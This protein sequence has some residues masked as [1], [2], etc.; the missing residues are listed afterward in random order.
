MKNIVRKSLHLALVLLLAGCAGGNDYQCALPE[1]PA[2]VVSFDLPKLAVRA[3]LDASSGDKVLNRFK[4]MAKS[5]LEGSGDMVDRIFADVAESGLDLNDKVYFFTNEEMATVGLLAKV[6]DSSKLESVMEVLHKQQLCQAVRETDGCRWTVLGKWLLAYSDQALLVLGDNKW[7]D[8]SKLVRQASMWLRQK[9]DQGFASKPDFKKIQENQSE[10]V[11]YTS[12]QL[13]SRQALAPLT[14]G[15]S[16]EVDLNKIKALT[17]V[18][19]E[20]GKVTLDVDPLVTDD[21]I[22]GLIEKKSQ[23]M[24]PV[25]GTYLDVFPSKTAFWT[26][27]NLKGGEFYQFLR[28][29]PA[30][31]KFFDYSDLPITLDFGRIFEAID[32]DVSVAITDPERGHFILYADV[33]Q[34]EFLKVFTELRPMIAKT[35]GMLILEDRGEN[36][37]C[38]ATH[39]GSL[40]NM[41][42]GP[43]IFWLGVKNGRFYFT[44]REDLIDSRVLGLSLRDC[45]WG[46]RV[47]GQHFFAVSNW[48]GLRTFEFLIHQ[49]VLSSVPK[50]IPPT[51]DYITIESADSKH[52]HI[53]WI[54]SD[55][56]QNFIQVLLQNN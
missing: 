37:Y 30:I 16:A 11:A 27:A 18:N 45:K 13:F 14:M 20:K 44:N 8:P 49:N 47:T 4:A 25:K 15:L 6:L 38:F 7:S 10:I 50:L 40:L 23:T 53:E 46:E 34:T 29:V 1:K 19:F 31:R 52:L 54:Q 55:K 33:T 17:A 26:T 9:E 22:K 48:K 28:E 2:A 56:K 21:I 42:P 41:H 32:G 51:L 39:D 35:N 3:G 24:R 43:K 12:L 36:A 5:G